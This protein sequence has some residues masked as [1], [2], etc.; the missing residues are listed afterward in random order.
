M[1]KPLT[2]IAILLF[3][4]EGFAQ[5]TPTP[6]SLW[7]KLFKDVQTTRAF[8]D[9]KTFVDMVPHQS[10]QVILQKYAG[11]RKRD[12]ASLRQFVQANFYLPANPET[13][14]QKGIS[15]RQHL[16]SLWTTLTRPKDSVR[17]NSSLLPLPGAYV[18]PGGRFRE[19]YYWDSYFT[20]QGLAV[21]NRFDLIEDM[22]ENFQHLIQTYGHIPNGNR[23]YYLSRSQPPFFALMV[24]LLATKQGDTV[25]KKYL[26]ALEKEYAFWM[27]GSDTLQAGQAH[28]RVVKLEDGTV[29]NRYF[30]DRNAPRQ[31]SYAEDL[32]TAKQ[33]RNKDSLVYT[34]LRAGAESG[35]DF[36]S[37]W[38]ADTLHLATIETTNIIPVDLNALLFS[39]ET[40]LSKA[41]AAAGQN[42][43]A[44]SFKEKAE[45]RQ[46]AVLRYCW[47]ADLQFFFDYDFK[48]KTT[49]NKWSAAGAMPLFTELATPHHAMFVEKTLRN[50][51]LKDGGIVTSL[52]KTGQ[53][54]DAPN[55]WAPL[56]F[57]AV[58]GL[59]NYGF[60]ELPKTIAERWMAINEKVF[61]ATGKMMEKYNVENTSLISGGGEYPTQDGFGWTNGVYLKFFEMFKST[62]GF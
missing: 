61:T 55:G 25:Y 48:E 49:T 8:G 37:R 27:E 3:I 6:D 60:Y 35:W 4:S 50:K 15:L 2:F 16:A 28:R 21:S 18:V 23:N 1:K 34:N 58:K 59:M 43:K 31:E 51:F 14:I 38:F 22:L 19:I 20:M 9:N 29:L 56:Q 33:Y 45:R 47:N 41:A 40:I 52:Y 62:T 10:P 54:W 30:D 12:S 42:E 7:G 36:S 11:L 24:E 5:V 39:Y 17:Q 13:K 32:H 57:V 26:P 53:Q 46:K 44:A